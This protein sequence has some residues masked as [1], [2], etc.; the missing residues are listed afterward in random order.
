VVAGDIGCYTLGAMPPYGTLESCVCMG[1]SI[2]MAKGASDAGAGPTLA[3][4]G[5]STFVHSGLTP[6]VDAAAHDTDMTLVILDNG[7][8][9][10]TGQQP[11]AMDHR[12]LKPT[13]VALGVDPDHVHVVTTH[14]RRLNELVDLL[15]AE[16]GHHGLSV[17]IA[18]RECLEAAR[19]EKRTRREAAVGGGS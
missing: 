9:A 13:I 11:T 17:I 15:R 19:K 1:A 12:R 3:V 4:V 7:T 8:V 10:M 18:G 6:L 5:D 14:P 2:G 16:I